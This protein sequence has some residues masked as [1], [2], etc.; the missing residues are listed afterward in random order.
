MLV[1]WRYVPSFSYLILYLT[2]EELSLARQITGTAAKDEII[3]REAESTDNHMIQVAC[4][5]EIINVL[6]WMYS[7]YAKNFPNI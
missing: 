2:L 5:R 6:D 7:H 1:Q 4:C 3:E